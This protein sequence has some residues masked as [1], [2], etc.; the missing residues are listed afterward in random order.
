MTQPWQDGIVRRVADEVR[1][2][3]GENSVQWL[4]DRTAELGYRISR[5]TISDM[6]VGR[7]TRLEVAE[8]IVLAKALGVPPILLLYPGIPGNPVEVL[9]GV[10]MDSLAAAQW[11]GG[12]SKHSW[13]DAWAHPRVGAEKEE[14]EEWSSGAL[15]LILARDEVEVLR[16]IYKTERRESRHAQTLIDDPTNDAARELLK[17]TQQRLS[18]LESDLRSVRRRQ[19]EA[20]LQ[21]VTLP[22]RF[23][24]SADD[25]E[26][27]D[28]KA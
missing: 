23:Q 7:R 2:L 3:R 25:Q 9:P 12:E 19:V 13:W 28:A 4:S 17:M 16:E 26:V 5:S 6:E 27:D 21:P 8:L 15:P 20:G 18:T 22:S 10:A 14:I 24:T 11:F 1:R